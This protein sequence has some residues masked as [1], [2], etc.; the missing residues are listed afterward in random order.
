[1][2]MSVTHQTNTHKLTNRIGKYT[3][4]FENMHRHSEGRVGSGGAGIANVVEDRLRK[5]WRVQVSPSRQREIASSPIAK[6]F[7]L[8][9]WEWPR[10]PRQ[11]RAYGAHERPPVFR[12][13]PLFKHLAASLDSSCYSVLLKTKFKWRV[14]VNMTSRRWVGLQVRVS[15]GTTEAQTN[16]VNA[17]SFG[18]VCVRNRQVW[19]VSWAAVGDDDCSVGYVKSVAVG[20]VEQ[21]CHHHVQSSRRVGVSVEKPHSTKYCHAYP[22]YQFS[23]VTFIPDT[24]QAIL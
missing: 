1:M 16:D 22:S 17:A 23:T 4:V 9:E 19:V 7:F 15:S 21:L 24:A 6:Q 5:D 11:T 2:C 3:A 14:R 18:F 8:G 12:V 10:I 20:D 13:S